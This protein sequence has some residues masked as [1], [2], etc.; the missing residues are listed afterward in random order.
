MKI[1]DI[2]REFKQYS[3]FE[4]GMTAGVFKGILCSLRMLSRYLQTQKLADFS[5]ESVRCFFYYGRSER[6]WSPKTYRNHWQYQKIF[7]DFCVCRGYLRQNPIVK[8]EKPRLPERIPRCLSRE[9]AQKVLCHTFSYPWRYQIETYRNHAIIATLMMAG[10]RLQELLN[11]ETYDVSLSERR[12]CVRQ[13]KGRKDRVVPIHFRLLPVLRQYI[14]KRRSAGRA[15]A[16]LFSGVRSDKQLSQKDVRAICKKVSVASGVK[17][18]PHVLRH[19]LG[20]ELADNQVDTKI[21]QK[22]LG[23]ASITTT[24][25]YTHLSWHPFENSFQKVR[26]Y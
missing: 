17:F 22:I 23:H 19:T 24:Q 7:F 11:L 16:W 3:L 5:T 15:G 9:D 13:G 12:L 18:S 26:I 8:L 10:L 14:E 4:K 2:Y 21:I 6:Q 20:R 1:A 25:I